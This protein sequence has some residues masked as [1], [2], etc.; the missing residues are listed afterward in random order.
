MKSIDLLAKAAGLSA[1]A[2]VLT[3]MSLRFS[4]PF[5][6]RTESS[7]SITVHVA[8]SDTVRPFRSAGVLTESFRS[9]RT[10]HAL[11]FQ[12][13]GVRTVS[14]TSLIG[15]PWEKALKS[16]APMPPDPT[17]SCFADSGAIMSSALPNCTNSMSRFCS[18]KYPFS[19]AM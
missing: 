11:D 1:Y 18:L 4:P 2:T 6:S 17:S 19:N 5:S 16:P 3:V 10:N 7:V 13:S 14:A 8:A 15:I 12:L 9:L